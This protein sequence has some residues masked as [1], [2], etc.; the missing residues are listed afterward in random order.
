M[1]YKYYFKRTRSDI[2]KDILKCLAVAGLVTVAASSPTFVRSLTKIVFKE[3][4]KKKRYSSKQFS[5]A[6]YR[7]KKE[8]CIVFEKRNKQIYIRLTPKGKTKA[9]WMQ[10]DDLKISKP[11]QWDKK[12]RLVMF[13]I[14]QPKKIYREALR[15]KLKQLGF[16]QF[17]KSV[18]IHAFDCQDELALLK[19]FFGLQD[20][21]LRL[22]TAVDIGKEDDLKGEFGLA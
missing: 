6:F 19:D 14:T 5:S 16:C 7:L 10:I 15:G 17:Q 18:W 21:E 13:D 22:V 11:R 1:K 20:S 2:V 3:L 8:E 12:W 4:T 9:G